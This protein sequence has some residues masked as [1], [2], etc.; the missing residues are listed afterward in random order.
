MP[1]PAVPY[2]WQVLFA[3]QKPH[4]S[5]ESNDDWKAVMKVG[6]G[7]SWAS[8]CAALCVRVLA[9]AAPRC[10]LHHCPILPPHS[11]WCCRLRCP[12]RAGSTRQAGLLARC[13]S[14]THPCCRLACHASCLATKPRSN[15]A[16]WPCMTLLSR[17]PPT[18]PGLGRECLPEP[19]PA[20]P[21]RQ[22]CVLRGGLPAGEGAAL[23]AG[24]LARRLSAVPG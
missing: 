24:G 21:I 20:R 6:A 12:G 9:S 14:C 2:P 7:G 19:P 4:R 16:P 17:S 3:R 5:T 23:G 13:R 18:L 8:R 22:Q 11:P 1:A 15:P 10:S